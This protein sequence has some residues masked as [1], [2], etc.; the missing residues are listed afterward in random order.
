MMQ[1]CGLDYR[2]K[3]MFWFGLEKKLM[4]IKCTGTNPA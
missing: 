3:L 4:D 2:T 1:L